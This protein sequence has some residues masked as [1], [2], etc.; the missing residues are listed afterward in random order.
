MTCLQNNLGIFEIEGPRP[1]WP[2]EHFGDNFPGR[3]IRS[4]ENLR[5]DTHN[6][7]DGGGVLGQGQD[8]IV[9]YSTSQSTGVSPAISLPLSWSSPQQQQ[10]R[11]QPQ[12]GD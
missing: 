1:L 5:W 12:E 2:G 9:L 10:I 11:A 7:H 4:I 3:G 6:R 8:L